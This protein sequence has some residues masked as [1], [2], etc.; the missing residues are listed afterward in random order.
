MFFGRL[1]ANL[2]YMLND[3]ISEIMLGYTYD[4]YADENYNRLTYKIDYMIFK[5]FLLRVWGN[6]NF[7]HKLYGTQVGIGI[8]I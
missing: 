4:E 1:T 6:A 5:Q 8:I 2:H 3:K 7:A